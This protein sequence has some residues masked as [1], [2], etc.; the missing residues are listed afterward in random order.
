MSQ[1]PTTAAD[2]GLDDNAPRYLG[3]SRQA[4][5]GSVTLFGAGYDGTT[6]F[7][8][9]TRFGPN[10]IREASDGLET[11]SPVQDRDL[12]DLGLCDLGNVDAS[13]GPPEPVLE[14]VTA[15]A[16]ALVGAGLRP[17]MLGGEHSLTP[18]AVRAAAAAHHDLVVV[19]L[20][21]HADLRAEYLGQ[22]NSHACAMRRCLGVDGVSA[23]VQVGIRSGT[24][25]EFAEMREA[26]RYVAPRP[27]AL[28]DRL[29]TLGERPIYLTVDLDVFD[30]SQLPGTGTP[31]PGG[32]DWAVFESLLSVLPGERIVA[33]DVMELAPTLDPTGVSS[34]LAAKVVREIVLRMG[35]R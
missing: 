24:R 8:P 34:I 22:P 16:A 20:D 14:R 7:R 15:A 35:P 33:A 11:Y 5:A 26:G 1:H 21:A 23:L 18:A 29:A 12:D 30:P 13:F 19:Q 10:A 9:G 25:Q 27:A 4:S 3:A 31:E 32:I 2:F 28:A 6:S 17:V